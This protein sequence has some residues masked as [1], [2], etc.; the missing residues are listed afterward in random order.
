MTMPNAPVLNYQSPTS[1]SVPL[2]PR[3]LA[4]MVALGLTLLMHLGSLVVGFMQMQ[5]LENVRAGGSIT[6]AEAQANDLRYGAVHVGLLI[7]LIVTCIALMM[8]MYRA[9]KNLTSWTTHRLD[10]TPGGAIGWW[11][12][13]FLNLVKP[14]QMMKEIFT[15]SHEGFRPRSTAVVGWWWGMWIISNIVTRIGAAMGVHGT[16]SPTIDKLVTATWTSMLDTPFALVAGLC[17]MWTIFCVDQVQGERR[18]VANAPALADVP[19]LTPV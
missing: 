19:R 3:T 18:N 5:L 6:T 7:G 12:C 1:Q 15:V 4:V 11:F 16:E 8:W 14:Y 2:R 17:L 13:P 9:N 10:F